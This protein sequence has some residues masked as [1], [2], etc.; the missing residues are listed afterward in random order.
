MYSSPIPK[1]NNY[2]IKNINSAL[3]SSTLWRLWRRRAAVE[4]A[5]DRH[6]GLAAA[7]DPL[8]VA[9]FVGPS[10]AFSR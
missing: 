1:E 6:G 10:L 4:S 9:Y 2:S 3:V 5:L 8:G 7:V